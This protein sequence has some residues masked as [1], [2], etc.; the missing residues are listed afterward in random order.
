VSF[1]KLGK[2]VKRTL[3]RPKW[4]KWTKLIGVV[5]GVSPEQAEVLTRIRFVV[6]FHSWK[7]RAK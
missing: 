5:A 1:K 6:A 3:L 7:R 4:E 2:M